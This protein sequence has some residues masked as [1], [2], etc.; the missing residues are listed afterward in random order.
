[1]EFCPNW[2]EKS[3]FLKLDNLIIGFSL[4]IDPEGYL[5]F[6]ELH[7]RFKLVGLCIVPM[8]LKEKWYLTLRGSKKIIEFCRN[9]IENQIL[10]LDQVVLILINGYDRIICWNEDF[11]IIKF[12]ISGSLK[13]CNHAFLAILD[14][15]PR[16][17]LIFI[18]ILWWI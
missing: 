9:G 12:K 1:M 18:D 3:S 14:L 16:S 6:D 2:I 4:N 11:F 8:S 13:V 15:I 17:L 7:W 5:K 10:Y